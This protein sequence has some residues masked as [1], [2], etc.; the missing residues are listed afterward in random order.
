[1]D[2]SFCGPNRASNAFFPEPWPF[3]S[4]PADVMTE[5]VLAVNI[6]NSTTSVGLVDKA[7]LQCRLH[8]ELASSGV[9]TGLADAVASVMSGGQ[10]NGVPAARVSCVVPSLRP[11]VSRILSAAGSDPLWVE[12]REGLAVRF[13]Y[14]DPATLGA[15][16]I[17]N[18]LYARAAV[19]GSD[20]IVIDAGTAITVDGVTREGVFAGGVILP[21]MALQIASLNTGAALLPR[22]TAG[23]HTPVFPGMSTVDCIRSGVVLGLGD[24]VHGLVSRFGDAFGAPPVVLA[25]GGSWPQLARLARID[26]THIPDLTLVGTA[27]FDTVS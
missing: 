3:S 18:C 22:I 14:E 7:N 13:D 25:C 4:L 5:N 27:L 17:A 24:A 20:V 21:G 1:M 23:S 26:H 12:A 8:S 10:Q 6:G 15:D 2:V 19:A 9:E 16:R 11:A